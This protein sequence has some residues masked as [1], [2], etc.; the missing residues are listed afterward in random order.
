[1]FFRTTLLTALIGA[2][3]LGAWAQPTYQQPQQSEQRQVMRF[4]RIWEPNQH[5]FQITIPS[6]WTFE[7]GTQSPQP[8]GGI[9]QMLTP[10]T[11][12]TV[13]S[14]D[15]QVGLQWFEETMMYS[16][17]PNPPP[18][19]PMIMQQGHYNGMPLVT[20]VDAAAAIE[21]LLIPYQR[22]G[23]GMQVAERRPLPT[24]GQVYA[25][26]LPQAQATALGGSITADAALITASNGQHDER[27]LAI[28][29]YVQMPGGDIIWSNPVTC[30]WW[31]PRGQ[32]PDWESLL[33]MIFESVEI[34]PDWLRNEMMRNART[35]DEIARVQQQCARIDAE[36]A[37]HRSQTN[38]EINRMGQ[39]NLMGMHD[40]VDPA[41]GNR[42]P[43][44]DWAQ[45]A[46]IDP[47]TG[48]IVASTDPDY[49]PNTDPNISGNF[50][51]MPQP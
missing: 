31:A 19:A 27:Y 3:A 33:G 34:N 50:T 39:L 45:S 13:T 44:P 37:N 28:C 8:L 36:I 43:M 29:Q 26:N 14:P 16:F 18:A 51:P 38:A 1:M 12:F 30:S 21:Q 20:A 4:Q 35:A 15:G 47:D 22:Q 23:Y 32:L 25:Q 48:E 42:T 9:G 17:G 11:N 5:A 46:H 2:I 40:R 41:T 24:V 49:D 10:K 7:G 6:G